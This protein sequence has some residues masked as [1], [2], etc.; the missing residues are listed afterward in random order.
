MIE[1]PLQLEGFKARSPAN[2][3][4]IDACEIDSGY[5]LPSDYK[6]FL[7]EHDGG[8]GFIG[9]SYAQLWGVRALVEMNR[10]YEVST[11]TPGLF[12]FGSSGGG[13]AFGFDYRISELAIIAVPF[14]VMAWEDA[15]PISSSFTGF[16]EMLFI[17]DWLKRR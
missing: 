16:I 7:V 6:D 5:R 9:A 13:E 17:G 10:E 15:I 11:Y 3:T 12:L 14:I 4:D 8:E 1:F 2:R